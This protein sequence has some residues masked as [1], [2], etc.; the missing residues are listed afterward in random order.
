MWQLTPAGSTVTAQRELNTLNKLAGIKILPYLLNPAAA[1]AAAAVVAAAQQGAD[2]QQQ[3]QQPAEPALPAEV[4]D[5]YFKQHLTSMFDQ[6]QVDAILKCAAHVQLREAGS[7]SSGGGGLRGSN[8]GSSGSNGGGWSPPVSLIQGPPG[9]GKTYTVL[10]V[11]NLWHMVLYHRHYASLDAVVRAL[12]EG[13]TEGPGNRIGRQQVLC[14][15][16]PAVQGCGLAGSVSSCIACC[17]PVG[18]CWGWSRGSLLYTTCCV[19]LCRP[20]ALALLHLL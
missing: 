8:D 13:S 4:A 19:G 5:S 16:S 17:V 1:A 12:V 6:P 20:C 7:S 18:M 10:G 11:L 3:Q 14:C 15:V 9:T 2:A